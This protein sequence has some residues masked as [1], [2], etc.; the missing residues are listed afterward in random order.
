[1]ELLQLTPT[2]LTPLSWAVLP[3]R[4]SRVDSGVVRTLAVIVPR[5]CHA[6]RLLAL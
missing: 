2:P 3:D 1:M 6:R 5:D 4:A